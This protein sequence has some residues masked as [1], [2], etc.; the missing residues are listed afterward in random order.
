MDRLSDVLRLPA[1]V[2]WIMGINNALTV[3]VTFLVHQHHWELYFMLLW[4]AVV[5]AANL[6]PIVV[7]RFAVLRS[8]T[9]YPAVS[10]MKLFRDFYKL[11]DW[12]YLLPAINLGFWVVFS[13][14][15]LTYRN[16]PTMISLL[17]TG[18][19]FCALIPLCARLRFFFFGDRRA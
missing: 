15:T 5:L 7:F 19:F 18:A 13:W 12:T 10:G 1:S 11:S 2:F 9:Y 17:L 4:L 6:L 16:I 14:V 3:F 8:T